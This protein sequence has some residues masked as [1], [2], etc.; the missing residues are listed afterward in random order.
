LS[1]TTQA[2]TGDF[3]ASAAVVSSPDCT[4][5]AGNGAALLLHAENCYFDAVD[6]VITLQAQSGLIT[7]D[8]DHPPYMVRIPLDGAT[9]EGN[10]G[11]N[12]LTVY[13][14]PGSLPGRRDAKIDIA[15][16]LTEPDGA[17]DGIDP[18]PNKSVV[19]IVNP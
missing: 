10:V 18:L 6:L 7:F 14:L 2:D 13:L 3:A 5:S 4:V 1:C 15:W 9:E 8:G 11:T 12:G 19:V 16:E 17:R